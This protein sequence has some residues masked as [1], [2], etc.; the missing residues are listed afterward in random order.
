MVALPFR[1]CT[2]AW[3]SANAG[4]ISSPLGFEACV[5]SVPQ[6]PDWNE[7]AHQVVLLYREGST[8]F[9]P[10]LNTFFVF[11]LHKYDRLAIVYVLLSIRD[12]AWTRGWCSLTWTPD[13]GQMPA[14]WES[15]SSAPQQ[16]QEGDM[17]VW[18]SAKD[19]LGH[20]NILCGGN[21]TST[22]DR[23]RP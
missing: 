13:L 18:F 21:G 1:R 4:S 15:V 8:I 10:G 9:N 17:Y 12:R 22:V 2:A 11:S 16:G 6:L 5:L 20:V 3:G 7:N 19:V 23:P 14:W